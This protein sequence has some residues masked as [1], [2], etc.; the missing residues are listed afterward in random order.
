MRS[1]GCDAA[2]LVVVVVVV[3]ATVVVVVAGP[4]SGGASAGGP[5]LTSD[6]PDVVG[7]T[8]AG[9]GTEV[10]VAPACTLVEPAWPG[11]ASPRRGPPALAEASAPPRRTGCGELPDATGSCRATVSEPSS[12]SAALTYTITIGPAGG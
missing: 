5:V 1:A 3:A 6:G 12:E 9:C 11:A 4:V 7:V 10:V 2:G 8:G